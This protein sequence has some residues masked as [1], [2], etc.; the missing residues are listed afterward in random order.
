MENIENLS[1][2]ELRERLKTYDIFL[3]LVLAELHKLRE[4]T[5]VLQPKVD[6]NNL[7]K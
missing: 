6:Q 3:K 7:G 2:E 1:I 4:K 5:P